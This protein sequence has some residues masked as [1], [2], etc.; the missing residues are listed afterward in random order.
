M[1]SHTYG[2]G[3]PHVRS[4][5]WPV[6]RSISMQS[7]VSVPSHHPGVSFGSPFFQFE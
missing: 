5:H 3:W 6:S 2:W 7:Y 4:F 1:F